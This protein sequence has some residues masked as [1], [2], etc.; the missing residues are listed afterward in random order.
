[1]AIAA[2]RLAT[3]YLDQLGPKCA[4]DR[5][6]MARMSQEVDNVRGRSRSLRVVIPRSGQQ[7]AAG[8]SAVRRSPPVVPSRDRRSSAPRR[9][10]PAATPSRSA[11]SPTRRPPAPGRGH[12]PGLERARRGAD[13]AIAGRPC[14]LGRGCRRIRPRASSRSR[15]GYH[16]RARSAENVLQRP[17][18]DRGQ[19]RMWNLLGIARFVGGDY[20]GWAAALEFELGAW[21]PA[22]FEA[23]QVSTHGNVAESLLTFGRSAGCRSPPAA[24][25][26]AGTPL[27]PALDDPGT[28]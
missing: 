28:C 16:A 19:G 12:R 4:L 11:C 5:V 25:P 26:A 6:W 24:V 15:S 1:M 9:A 17:L 10:S 23:L 22:G 8:R 20:A 2:D 3:W 13:I 27:R 7:L 21:Q 14:A 18:Q